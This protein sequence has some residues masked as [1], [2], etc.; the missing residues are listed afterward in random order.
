MNIGGTTRTFK[1]GTFKKNQFR[2]EIY[3]KK[4]NLGRK[5]MGMEHFRM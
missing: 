1:I 5:F 3:F 2:T 4:I